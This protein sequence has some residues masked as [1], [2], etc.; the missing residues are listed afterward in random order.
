VAFENGQGGLQKD[1]KKAVEWYRKAAE[2][3]NAQAQTYL[4]MAFENGQGGIQKDD[5]KAV[6]WYRK[7]A[8]QNNS[9]A[10]FALGYRYRTGEGVTQDYAQAIEW[11]RKSGDQGNIEAINDLGFMYE[12]GFGVAIDL[13]KAQALYKS[14]ADQGNDLAKNNLAELHNKQKCFAK[15]S[16]RL[17]DQALLCASKETLRAATKK[18][19]A[20]P[21]RE[22]DGYWYDLYDSSRVLEGTSKLQIAYSEGKFAKAIYTFNS[23]MDTHKVVEVR[24]LVASKYGY[25]T[26]SEGSPSVGEVKY[27]WELKDGMKLTVNRGWPDAT[28][29]LSYIHPTNF[30]AME[31]EQER[32]KQAAE[33][34]KRSKQSKSF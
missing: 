9:E 23:G 12:N 8:E 17:F 1:D 2:Q 31:A 18:A 6:E 5:S 25:P 11:Y 34:E 16:T 10:Q 21:T 15:D 4:G 7:A 29:Y 26:S 28:V 22:N 13:D 3:G 19:G 33:D 24:D 20:N 32:Q 27:T 30:A 14:S